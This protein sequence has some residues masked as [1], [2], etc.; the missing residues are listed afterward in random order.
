MKAKSRLIDCYPRAW[1]ERYGEELAELL[2]ERMRP[3]DVLD[4]LCGAANEWMVLMTGIN[5]WNDQAQR[6]AKGLAQA[7]G[8]IIVFQTL[9]PTI[10]SALFGHPIYGAATWWQGLLFGFVSSLLQSAVSLGPVAFLASIIPWHRVPHCRI[11]AACLGA[12]VSFQIANHVAW[13]PMLLALVLGG[14]WIGS[15]TPHPLQALQASTVN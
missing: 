2:G 10:L 3:R 1:R 14:A 8:S 12:L 7:A 15:K 11:A 9:V 4:V 6:T 13:G 5:S